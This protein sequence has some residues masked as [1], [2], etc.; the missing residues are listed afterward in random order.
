MVNYKGNEKELKTYQYKSSWNSGKTIVV[1]IPEK[2][3]DDV[4]AYAHKI[5]NENESIAVTSYSNSNN[6]SSELREKLLI[7]VEK[8]KNKEAGYKSNSS[9]KLIRELMAL[10]EN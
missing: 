7:I 5:E 1:R 3:K 6:D 9:A 4:L 8:I 2:I 10:V